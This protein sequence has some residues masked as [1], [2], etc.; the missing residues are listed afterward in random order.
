MPELSAPLR[1]TWDL[2]ADRDLAS[3]LWERL[4]EA[5]VLAA[6]VRV[7]ETSLLALAAV[8][9]GSPGPRL[10]VLGAADV[11][12]RAARILGPE[13]LANGCELLLLPPYETDDAAPTDACRR[14][15]SV[16]STPE[17]IDS[18][19]DALAAGLRWGSDT[20]AVL[21]PPAGAPP[22]DGAARERAAATWTAAPRDG[23]GLRVHDLFLAEILGL[24]PLAGYAG[25]QAGGTVAHVTGEGMLTA[26]RTLP[27]PLGDLRSQSL[28]AVWAASARKELRARLARPPEP[29]GPCKLVGV[30]GGGCRGYAVGRGR[31]PGCPGVR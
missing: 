9:G 1:V 7:E 6:E 19:E 20:V 27:T 2:P 10:S 30:C 24:D 12:M 14:V 23:V 11:A 21:N 31:D 16:W 22:L 5:R 18:F 4:V 13:N 15:P 3:G 25:C 17:G 29:C 28:A 26:C 8:A